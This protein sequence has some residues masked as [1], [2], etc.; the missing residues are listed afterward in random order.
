MGFTSEFEE[1][2]ENDMLT[3]TAQSSVPVPLEYSVFVLLKEV[4][5]LPATGTYLCALLN[6]YHTIKS[7][8]LFLLANMDFVDEVLELTFL[9]NETMATA[10]VGIINDNVLE[11]LEQFE[12]TFNKTFHTG[13]YTIAFNVDVVTVQIVDEDGKENC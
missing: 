8:F 6:L 11:D 13:I 7:V 1:I 9:A 5:N 3:L 4:K 12:A 10:A 2:K